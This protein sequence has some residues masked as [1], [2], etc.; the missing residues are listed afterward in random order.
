M[1]SKSLS[2]NATSKQAP[3]G[4]PLAPSQ[5][6]QHAVQ[7]PADGMWIRPGSLQPPQQQQHQQHQHQQHQQQHNL[8]AVPQVSSSSRGLQLGIGH[9]NRI[10]PVGSGLEDQRSPQRRDSFEPKAEPAAVRV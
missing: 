5:Q 9:A 1:A 8:P 10:S 7:A 3:P 6:Q 4:Q 2:G